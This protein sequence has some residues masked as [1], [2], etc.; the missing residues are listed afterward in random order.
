MPVTHVL[1]PN[2]DVT[3][4][5]KD[6]D[7]AFAHGCLA[8]QQIYETETETPSPSNFATN[9]TSFPPSSANLEAEAR[10]KHR[11][12]DASLSSS[13]TE[14]RF[15]VSSA[16]LILASPVFKSALTGSWKE[17]VEFKT[18]GTV[19]LVA[20]GWNEEALLVFLRIIHCMPLELPDKM[21]LEALAK[22]AVVADFYDCMKL[23]AF[24]A[25][26]WL[27][28]ALAPDY[29]SLLD[30][31]NDRFIPRNTLRLWV[32][33]AF[34]QEDAFKTHSQHLISYARDSITPL[35]LPLPETVIDAM[36]RHREAAIADTLNQLMAK[37]REILTFKPG[38]DTECK[39]RIRDALNKFLDKDR[40]HSVTAPYP[41]ISQFNLAL[42][43]KNILSRG[44]RVYHEN[45]SKKWRYH[46]CR[47]SKF[48]WIFKELKY[49]IPGL[50]L[51]DLKP[52]Y[53]SF[54]CS[55]DDYRGLA[56]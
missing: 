47:H 23:I 16:H 52:W 17:S 28:T 4:I 7:A 32:S 3:L 2:G 45:D 54:D 11:A 46:K 55:P 1:D 37:K 27:T 9:G 35:G 13:S 14:I 36:N 25:D 39:V 48:S 30:E 33:W 44:W 18:K 53:F 21:P 31:D 12:D 5:L 40:L 51:K 42:A 41:D 20:I 19:E 38:C 34:H 24:F 29:D 22:L 50:D 15:Q 8:P 43:A 56:D 26:T 49:R 10:A 6:P